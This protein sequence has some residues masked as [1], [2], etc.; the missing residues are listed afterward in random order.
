MVQGTGQER[1]ARPGLGCHSQGFHGALVPY[2]AVWFGE[3]APHRTILRLTQ[4]QRTAP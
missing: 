3:R 2:D 1:N 4:T